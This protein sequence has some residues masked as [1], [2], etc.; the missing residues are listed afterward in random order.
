VIFL[1]PKWLF[2]HVLALGLVVL[3]AN[4]GFWQLS[5][6]EARQAYNALLEERLNAPAVPFEEINADEGE[7]AYRPVLASGVFDPEHEVLQRSRSHQGQ[8]GYHVLTPLVLESGRAILVDR[9]WV[10]YE[11]DEPPVA[12]ALPPEGTITLEG[13]LLPRQEPPG[14]GARDPAEGELKALFWVDTERLSGQMPYGLEPVYLQ[15]AMQLPPQSGRYPIPPEPL[16]I[17]DGPHLGYALQW[18]SFA[19]IGIVGYTLLLRKVGL[20]ASQGKEVDTALR[21]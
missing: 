16:V 15:L 10:P 14:F 18:F 5:R 19:L 7:L 20:E 12:E 21:E 9:G 8:P 13:V 2:G 3:F 4:F 11:L 17:D 1:T 6:L